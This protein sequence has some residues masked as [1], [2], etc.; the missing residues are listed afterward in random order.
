[1]LPIWLLMYTFEFTADNIT[2]TL[3]AIYNCYANVVDAN[4]P[5][6]VDYPKELYRLPITTEECY[7]LTLE[8]V[9]NNKTM[10][11]SWKSNMLV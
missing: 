2:K 6:I 10:H 9:F 4:P 8:P 1:M 11:V 7:T 3:E 5:Y